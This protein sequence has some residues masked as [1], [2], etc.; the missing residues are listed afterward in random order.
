MYVSFCFNF[1]HFMFSP[2]PEKKSVLASVLIKSS[3]PVKKLL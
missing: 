1:P 3:F 2:S